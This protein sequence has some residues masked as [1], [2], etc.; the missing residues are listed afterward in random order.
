MGDLNAD[1]LKPK[2]TL[3]AHLLK[4]L[5]LVGLKPHG[6]QPTRVSASTSTCLDLITVPAEIEI[7]KYST[8][9][10]GASDHFPVQAI[11]KAQTSTKPVP[12]IKRS[13]KKVDMTELKTK[14][15]RINLDRSDLSDPNELLECWQRSVISILDQ[16]APIKSY[17]VCRKSCK[18]M[19]TDIRK[20]IQ[21]RNTVASKIENCD[22]NTRA[23]TIN[24]YKNLKAIVK[25]RLRRSAKEHGRELLAET[26][27][28]NVWSFLREVSFTTTKG[29]RTSMD[30]TIL[31]DQLA[32][33]VQRVDNDELKSI[34]G[35]DCEDSFNVVSL[36]THEVLHML[37]RLP[38]KT[39]T[40]PDGL[41]AALLK[42]LAPDIADNLT[43]IMNKSLTEGA[44]PNQWK[45]ANV[46]AIWKGKGAKDDP[47]NYRPISVLPVLARLFEKAVTTQLTRYCVSHNVIP[48]EQFGF[49]AK[50]NCEM[51]L[52]AALDSWMRKVDQGEVVGALLIDLSKAFDT[53]PHQR[54]LGEL[55]KI[56]CGVGVVRW[57]QS[58]LTGRE[59]RVTCGPRQTEWRSVSRGVPQGSSISPL[60]FNIYVRNLPSI[61]ESDTFQFADDV[62][63]SDSDPSEAKVLSRLTDSFIQTK[64]FCQDHDLIINTAKTQLILFKAPSKKL[65]A[66]LSITIDGCTIK[67][68]DSVKLLGVILDK[69]FTFGPH[70]DATVKKA[71]GV[72]GAIARAAPHLPREL[73]RM[74]YISLVRTLLKYASATFA[75]SSATQ[76]KKLDTV[77][78]VASRL[79]CRAPR[80]AHSAP[81]LE[82]LKL[83]PLSVRRAEH[84]IDL[85][86]SIVSNNIHP[87][88]LNMFQ[89]DID[90]NIAN[91]QTARIGIGRRR[92]SIYAKNLANN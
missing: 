50:S 49:R 4:S 14:V 90:D 36:H 75:S 72:L 1:L 8:I 70:I 7:I 55:T 28:R 2:E 85:V 88:L 11:L 23:E 83:Q 27:T 6:T 52:I 10:L 71:N 19:T 45:K 68:S 82:S 66:D 58:Y 43:Y 22:Q 63:N 86:E 35:C 29:E 21:E 9:H 13:F 74:A 80:Q 40:G 59:Q 57:F 41:P 64:A 81:L 24:R 16:V 30:L 79:I 48:Q 42:Q 67:P 39:A 37:R 17:P 53:V 76:L 38:N 25:S 47:T 78:K 92:F 5:K 12:V 34:A 77:Q 91:N 65:Q 32:N 69:H 46:A 73:L 33:C 84:V 62:T 60:L 54:L 18:W 26:N 61:T 89:R 31:N 87:A 3:T 56:G 20:L 51:T 15:A 44:F